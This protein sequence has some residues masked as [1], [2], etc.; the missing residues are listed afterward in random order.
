MDNE[1]LFI[2]QQIS[3]IHILRIIELS[4]RIIYK[5]E[6]IGLGFIPTVKRLQCP[7]N[8]ILESS[9]ARV[10]MGFICSY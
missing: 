8:P 3:R 9:S 10:K 4:L 6:R 5:Y 7:F 1:E 2:Y